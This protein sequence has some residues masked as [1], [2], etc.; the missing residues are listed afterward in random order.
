MA[1]VKSFKAD[2]SSITPV[3]ERRAKAWNISF[4]TIYDGRFTLSAQLI[5]PNYLVIHSHWCNITVSLEAYP[6]FQRSV[7]LHMVFQK[8]F[9]K[10]IIWKQTKWYYYLIILIKDR[11]NIFW[12]VKD[13]RVEAHVFL[14]ECKNIQ[15][16]RQSIE[17]LLQKNGYRYDHLM[18]Y[19]PKPLL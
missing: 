13:F 15:K 17:W 8:N 11:R 7:L 9:K 3:S 14:C 2:V 10:Y 5:K 6:L 16:I 4:E 1:N 18:E 12:P 19:S